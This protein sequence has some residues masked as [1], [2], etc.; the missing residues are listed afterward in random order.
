[1]SHRLVVKI[2]IAF[3]ILFILL[4][5]LFNVAEH[6]ELKVTYALYLKDL[7][8]PF[9]WIGYGRTIISCYASLWVFSYLFSRK[10]YVLG[11]LSVIV[12]IVLDMLFRYGIE[13]MF[14]GPVFDLWQFYR[15]ITL[16]EYFIQ[17]MLY[18]ALGI[19]VCF[20][21]KIVNDFFVGEQIR[22]ERTSIE[23]QFL[24]SQ[25]NPH[26]LFNSFNNLYGLSLT[27]PHKT[28]DAILKLAEFTRYMIYES[29][30]AQVAL[31]KEIS[32]L[33]NLIELQKLRYE[34][35]IFVDFSV[36]G[37]AKAHLIA[38]LLLISFVENAFKHGKVE[39]KD[40]PIKI[41]LKLL[42]KELYFHV[43]NTIKRGN[44]DSSGGIGMKNV[45]RRLELLYPGA[46]HLNIT[47]DGTYYCSELTLIL[48]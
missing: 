33:K 42:D 24:K 28:P 37:C 3:W 2:H 40:H 29:N 32:Y 44:K 48:T 9:T 22:Q 12:L 25:I 39:E 16:K 36:V 20:V 11:V 4:G 23:L 34:D 14:I 5:I 35:G 45:K 18:S 19:F 31:Q 10:L 1:M 27:E 17:N 47:N 43:S 21:L 13:Q 30:E 38:P 15:G 6:H 8:D 26:F 41:S 46:H 7:K